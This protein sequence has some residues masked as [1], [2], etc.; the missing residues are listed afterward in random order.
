MSELSVNAD[1]A[2]NRGSNSDPVYRAE[3]ALMQR[4]ANGDESALQMLV[5]EHAQSL[6]TFIGRLMAWHADCDDIFQE[7]LLTV[8]QKSDRYKGVGSLE[9]WLKRIAVNRCRNHFRT[10]NVIQRKLEQLAARL[11]TGY[12]ETTQTYG[13]QSENQSE[14]ENEALRMALAKLHAD[15]RTAVVLFYLEEWPGQ[16]VAD[17]LGI[18][19]ETL[20]VRL[21]RIKKKL[22]QWMT[23]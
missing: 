6:A 13:S 17:S 11:T 8:W 23:E 21:H 4:I 9:G 22:K 16:E 20:H 14:P 7:V 5:E 3:L 10:I 15:D 12:S 18:R 19:A 1:V 2:R